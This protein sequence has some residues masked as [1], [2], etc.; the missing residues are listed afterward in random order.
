MFSLTGH[1]IFFVRVRPLPNRV[2]LFIDGAYLEYVLR[3]EFGSPRLDFHA[4]SE[5]IA[6]DSEILRS[7]YYHCP[8]YQGNPPTPEERGRY[9]SQRK[10]FDALERLPRY[11][12]RL[13]RLERRGPDS[14]GNYRFEQKRVDILLGVDL[15]LL[16]AKQ[17]IQEAVL[18]A[19]D[20]DFIPAISVAKAEGVLVRLYHGA[21]PHTD[22]WREADERI[23]ITKHL[24]DSVPQKQ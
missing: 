4:F 18:I 5:A 20:S 14:L 19:G 23:P 21:N 17:S 6:G 9:S 3:E 24:I 7:Y 1:L 10:F 16:A 8:A 15:V 11:S 2:A 12:V 13:G 22:L